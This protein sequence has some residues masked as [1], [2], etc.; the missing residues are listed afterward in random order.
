MKTAKTGQLRAGQGVQWAIEGE[1]GVCWL[2]WHRPSTKVDSDRKRKKV[3]KK[4]PKTP[5]PKTHEPVDR[6]SWISPT[7]RP[8]GR[9]LGVGSQSLWVKVSGCRD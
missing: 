3:F 9:I 2:E 5:N 6:R 7:P 1:D 4:K 8:A